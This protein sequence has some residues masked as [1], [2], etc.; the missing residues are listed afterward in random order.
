M[1]RTNVHR[2]QEI[3]AGFWYNLYKGDF[4]RLRFGMQYKYVTLTA[5]PWR[6]RTCPPSGLRPRRRTRVLAPTTRPFSSR[7]VTIRST[8]L[9][10]ANKGVFPFVHVCEVIDGTLD[11]V[12]HGSRDMP[13][14]GD[15]YRCDV[16][17]SS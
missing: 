2:V 6:V 10:E 8:E 17:Q 3:T 13:I 1:Y 7:F 4:G 15:Y 11:V 16:R 5:F 12:M 14:L 9:S